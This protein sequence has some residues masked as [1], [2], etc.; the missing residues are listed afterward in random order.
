[1]RLDEAYLRERLSGYADRLVE[2]YKRHDPR[3]PTNEFDKTRDAYQA[4]ELCWRIFDTAADWA[5]RHIIGIEYAAEKNEELLE[6]D[7]FDGLYSDNGSF[8]DSHPFLEILPFIEEEWGFAGIKLFAEDFMEGFDGLELSPLSGS[9]RRSYIS[10]LLTSHSAGSFAWRNELTH[11]LRALNYG[12]VLELARPN[13]L[14]GQGL[15]YESR[16]W[17]LQA[18]LHVQFMIGKGIKKSVAMQEVATAV[19]R[20]FETIRDWETKTDFDTWE[21]FQ[22]EAAHLAGEFEEELKTIR[23]HHNEPSVELSQR[24]KGFKYTTLVELAHFYVMGVTRY[25]MNEIAKNLA[26]V[27]SGDQI[28][29][30]AI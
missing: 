10:E 16:I 15:L 20:S 25:E 6:C 8:N 7:Q 5:Q 30:K 2:L 14:K 3:T 22:I 28:S 24:N 18:L 4:I 12:T 23:L 26:R 13:A 21:L 11:S 19:G 1:M 27:L 9:A 29:P 17:K